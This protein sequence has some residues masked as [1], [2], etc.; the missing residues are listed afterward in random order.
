MRN[1]KFNFG[2]IVIVRAKMIKQ[3]TTRGENYYRALVKKELPSGTIGKISGLKYFYVGEIRDDDN[4]EGYE[5]N[6]GI[7]HLM[8]E[9]SALL[10]E[11][12]VGWLNKP[13][14]ARE[15]D[16][17]AFSNQSVY[18]FPMLHFYNPYIMSE[19]DRKLLSKWSKDFPRDSKGRF[20]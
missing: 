20:I 1:V 12:K 13:I 17:E 7:R 19:K 10:Y 5:Y 15:S 3:V 8:V 2:E 6:S 16:L 4:F 11:I 14:Y 9:S 18:K